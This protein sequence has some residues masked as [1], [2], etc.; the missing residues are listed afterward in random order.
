MVD[1]RV[2]AARTQTLQSKGLGAIAQPGPVLP[3]PGYRCHAVT[4][5]GSAL[6][7]YD[8][9]LTLIDG[10]SFGMTSMID[11]CPYCRRLARAAD[12]GSSQSP[13]KDRLCDTTEAMSPMCWRR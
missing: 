12:G 1:Y 4:Q 7:G 6:C 13:N 11:K 5:D 9:P 3:Y 8:G 10:P 2:G